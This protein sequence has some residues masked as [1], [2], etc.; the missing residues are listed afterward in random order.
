MARSVKSKSKRPAAGSS[1][2][3]PASARQVRIIAGEFR[4]RRLTFPDLPGLRP[5]A[6]RVRETLFNWLQTDVMAEH[7]L[8][9]FAGSGACGFECLSRGATAVTFVDRSSEV[10]GYLHRGAEQLLGKQSDRQPSVQIHQASAEDFLNRAADQVSPYG[11]VF[12]DPPFADDSLLDISQQ[13]ENSGVLKT[14]ALVYVESGSA[15]PLV[16]QLSPLTNWRMLK[17]KKAGAVRFALF[18]RCAATSMAGE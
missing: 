3:R 2:A 6:D 11:L 14:G 13:L 15:I 7:C 10:C 12:L 9:L 18:Q 8:D 4:G 1:L 17:E 5:T 16:D